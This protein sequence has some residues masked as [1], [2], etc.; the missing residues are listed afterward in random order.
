M[1]RLSHVG[2]KLM[3]LLCGNEGRR[4]VQKV[5]VI[6]EY[7]VASRMN[8]YR[9]TSNLRGTS[10]TT[11]LHRFL[12]KFFDTTRETSDLLES[13]LR[14]IDRIRGGYEVESEAD[15]SGW[16]FPFSSSA[17]EKLHELQSSHAEMLHELKS[18]WRKMKKNK[19]ERNE[20][21]RE[22]DAAA[23][24]VYILKHDLAMMGRLVKR[25]NNEMQHMKAIEEIIETIPE[26]R[27]SVEAIRELQR[28]E[29]C[30]LMKHMEELEE[31]GSLCLLDISRS[32]QQ[33]WKEITKN[34]P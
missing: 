7:E 13:I 4:S 24:W 3:K 5:N 11:E 20:L 10:E 31:H 32:R 27:A 34:M 9:E 8:S 33:I 29:E 23:R 18:K 2:K 6:R 1:I 25:V 28:Q 26:S 15:E 22:L 19:S 14:N 21:Q 12:V 30:C 17:Q 16:D